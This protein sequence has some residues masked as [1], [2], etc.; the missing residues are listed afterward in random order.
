MDLSDEDFLLKYSNLAQGEGV[1]SHPLRLSVDQEATKN[2]SASLLLRVVID[3]QV[4]QDDL[5]EQL[6]R[7]WRMTSQVVFSQKGYN[8]FL[9][10]FYSV[11]DANLVFNGGPWTYRTAP[12]A[13]ARVSG[14]Q[15][16]NADHITHVELWVQMHSN[17]IESISQPDALNLAS[18]IG[19]PVSLPSITFSD[20]A[21]YYRTR[22]SVPIRGQIRD[23]HPVSHPTVG[24][25][26]VFFVYE[27]IKKACV[28]CKNLGHEYSF[29]QDWARFSRLMVQ[30]KCKQITG[31]QVSP[32]NLGP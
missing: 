4:N 2:W 5:V 16:I 20:G 17:F 27:R 6:L 29:C 8:L 3:R 18:Q 10:D 1:S 28:F 24:N 25:F 11:Q 22:I 9:V 19:T 23:K 26:L 21:K 7:A 32:F 13:V 14:P 30:S 15:D 31:D 12:I